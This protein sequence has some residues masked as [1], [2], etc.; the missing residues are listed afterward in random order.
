M[1][2]FQDID[3]SSLLNCRI[4]WSEEGCWGEK[5]GKKRL[6]FLP[7]LFLQLAHEV[8]WKFNGLFDFVGVPAID[9]FFH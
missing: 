4:W 3:L 6:G 7:G 1:F 8:P 9:Y 2:S 5:G